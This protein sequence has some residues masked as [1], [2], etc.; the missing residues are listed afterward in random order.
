MDDRR[1]AKLTQL[2]FEW[3]FAFFFKKKNKN[4]ETKGESKGRGLPV[5]FFCFFSRRVSLEEFYNQVITLSTIFLLVSI[6]ILNTG[7]KPF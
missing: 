1:H 4:D 6:Y 3:Y 7:N 2:V 5:F